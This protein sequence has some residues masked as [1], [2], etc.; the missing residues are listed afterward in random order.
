MGF[1]QQVGNG[2]FRTVIEWLQLPGA[3]VLLALLIVVA[4]WYL[5]GLLASALRGNVTRRF[6]RRSVANLALR[7][8]RAV[9]VL[10]ALFVALPVLG[11]DAG[12]VLVSVTVISAVIGVVL[13]PLA[14]N[15]VSGMLVLVNRPY[16][17]GDMIE[18]VD[19]DRRGYVDDITLRYTRIVTLDNTFL[20]IPNETITERDVVNLSG[21]DERTRVSVEFTVTYEGDLERAR[22][23]AE[24]V[25]SDIDGVLTGGPEIRIGS[26]RYPARPRALIAGFDDHGVRVDLRFWVRRPYL[27]LEMRS[28][29]HEALWEAFEDADVEIPYPH[30]HLVF[31][32]TSG[33]AR[34][35]L[36]RERT[37]AEAEGGPT[38]ESAA[39]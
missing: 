34:V 27:P 37:L 1:P 33:R 36:E 11:F 31:D 23:R 13:A 17:I 35:E 20:L 29:V 39:D 22:E 24:G 21:E 10:G 28:T 32:E 4:G 2:A 26:F 30:T 38:A 8:V 14:Q 12:N 18:I 7:G 6:R 9:V 3:N 16:E 19:Q 5:S 15:A 25:I